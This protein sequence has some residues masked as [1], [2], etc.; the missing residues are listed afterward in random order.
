SFPVLDSS[1]AGDF[2]SG[3]GRGET[4][5]DLD[6]SPAATEASRFIPSSPGETEELASENL[7]QLST[8]AFMGLKEASYVSPD[9]ETNPVEEQ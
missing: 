5:S 4:F 9:L 2:L 8:N 3:E 1:A 7:T 6:I